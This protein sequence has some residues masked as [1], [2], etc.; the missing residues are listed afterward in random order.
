M[1]ALRRRFPDSRVP[2]LIGEQHMAQF[3]G[4]MVAIVTPMRGGQVDERALRELAKWQVEEGTDGLVPC[5]TTGEGA[6]LTAEE[7]VRVNRICVEE[8]RGRVPVIAG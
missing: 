6:T 4:S 8:A 5:G 1:C 2:G 7:A 3:R